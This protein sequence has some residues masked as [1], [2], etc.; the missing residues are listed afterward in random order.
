MISRSETAPGRS[1]AKNPRRRL[2]TQIEG[3]TAIYEFWQRCQHAIRRYDITLGVTWLLCQHGKAGLDAQMLGG[4]CATERQYFIDGLSFLRRHPLP[5]S[6]LKMFC[7]WMIDVAM[8]AVE[9]RLAVACRRMN[10]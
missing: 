9:I 7:A 6:S 5:S 2:A 1:K 10:S 3:Y 4:L 8:A